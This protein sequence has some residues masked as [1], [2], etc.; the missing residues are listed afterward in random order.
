MTVSEHSPVCCSFL[1]RLQ[2]THDAK[3]E[4]AQTNDLS[5]LLNA[6]ETIPFQ[7]PERSYDEQSCHPSMM[8]D[9][10]SVL[11]TSPRYTEGS[12]GGIPHTPLSPATFQ[13]A[14]M[15]P[16]KS[17]S[18]LPQGVY[19]IRISGMKLLWGTNEMNPVRVSLLFPSPYEVS[20]QQ[21]R[22]HHQLPLLL[23]L[24]PFSMLCEGGSR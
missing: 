22:R 16:V 3:P 23:R 1:L 24:F 2:H 5:S 20:C 17:R 14:V 10:G 21:R 19:R 4:K 18:L 15:S 12:Y 9:Q 11:E 6:L 13:P 7:T 8:P